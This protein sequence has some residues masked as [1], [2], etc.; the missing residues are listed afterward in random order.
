MAQLVSNF[1][2]ER[3]DSVRDLYAR[4]A[5]P[6]E[7]QALRGMQRVHA[8]LLLY[9]MA[10]EVLELKLR[11]L[12]TDGHELGGERGALACGV[13]WTAQ[14]SEEHGGRASTVFLL[15]ADEY[16]RYCTKEV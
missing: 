2:M 9:E 15:L 5:R 4:E 3:G 1:R 16:V 6:V 14:A 12:G 10:P 7:R 13:R 11:K 8:E